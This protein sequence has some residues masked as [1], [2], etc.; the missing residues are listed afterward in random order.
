[1]CVCICACVYVCVQL[2]SKRLFLQVVWEQSDYFSLPLEFLNTLLSEM[3]SKGEWELSVVS[4]Q[5]EKT[6]RD[7]LCFI[8]ETWNICAF[9]LIVDHRIDTEL[10]SMPNVTTSARRCQK[11]TQ[12][13][14][15]HCCL[16]QLHQFADTFIQ[17]KNH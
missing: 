7:Y 11:T 12:S 8:F 17:S 3:W 15:N 5:L 6:G 9:S 14:S 1:M 16:T 13:L 2:R 4:K 10:M